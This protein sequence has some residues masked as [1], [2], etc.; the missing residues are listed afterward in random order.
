MTPSA[1]SLLAVTVA[2]AAGA[3]SGCGE[4]DAEQQTSEA[5]PE[6]PAAAPPRPLDVAPHERQMRKILT[7]RG[8]SVPIAG[9]LGMVETQ[10]TPGTKVTDVNCPDDVR[11]EKGAVFNCTV[12]GKQGLRGNVRITLRN[13]RGDRFRFNAKVKSRVVT[14]KIRGNSELAAR[15]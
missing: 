2:C 9:P 11:P 3:A 15:P 12:R 13:K 8:S 14:R 4:G 5:R 6:K 7:S 10:R 1:R